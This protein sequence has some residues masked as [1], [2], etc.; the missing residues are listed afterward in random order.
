MRCEVL[1]PHFRFI[2]GVLMSFEPLLSG[3]V[4]VPDDNETQAAI[5]AKWLMQVAEAEGDVK[6]QNNDR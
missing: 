1:L 6:G 5:K 3:V 4:D 2:D